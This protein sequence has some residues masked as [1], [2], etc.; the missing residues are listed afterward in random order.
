[1][2]VDVGSLPVALAP[3]SRTSGAICANTESILKH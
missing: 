2:Q 1:M 3:Q